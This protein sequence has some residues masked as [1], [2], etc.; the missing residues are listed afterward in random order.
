M[1]VSVQSKPSRK[2]TNAATWKFWEHSY[3]L[4]FAFVFLVAGHA[5]ADY[6]LQGDFLAKAK[7]RTAPI[8][9]ITW[10]QALAAHSAI[11]AGFVL[12]I[13]QSLPCAIVEFIAHAITDD[14]KCRGKISF[15]MDQAIHIACKLVY[16]AWLAA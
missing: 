10:Q 14:A 13:T 15:N 6:P 11:H 12:A 2:A 16:V 3:D 9:G 7:N 5:L 1:V 4:V 8:P